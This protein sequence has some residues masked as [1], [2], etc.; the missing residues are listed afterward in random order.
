MN[1]ELPKVGGFQSGFTARWIPRSQAKYPEYLICNHHGC[2][3]VIQLISNVS[4]EPEFELCP[5]EAENMAKVLLQ[6]VRGPG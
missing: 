4:G 1:E 3:R 2:G 6:A 5:I